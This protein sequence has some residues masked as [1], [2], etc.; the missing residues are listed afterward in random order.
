MFP[1]GRRLIDW[2]WKKCFD[3]KK[4]KVKRLEGSFAAIVTPFNKDGS[5]DIEGF[6]A[7][8]DFHVVNGTSGLLT[9]GSHGKNDSFVTIENF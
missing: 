7:L 2:A 3:L 8:I 4:M 6:R 9:M 1:P 5:V